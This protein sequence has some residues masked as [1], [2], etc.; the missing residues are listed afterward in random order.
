VPRLAPVATLVLSGVRV[1]ELCLLD[2][3]YLDSARRTIHVPRV[4]TDAAERSIPML[5][6]LYELLL[7]PRRVG[8]RAAGAGVRDPQ[9]HAQ[10]ARQGARADLLGHTDPKFTMR[11]Y[12]Q[13][14]DLG[15]SVPE[16]LEYDRR[17][18]R[19]LAWR[20][21]FSLTPEN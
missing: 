8:L 6:L 3:R 9:R 13:V 10:P 21:Y 18:R 5:P 19:S 14:R 1:S 11:V 16:Q 17:P 15:G 4:K 12:Q 20:R 7:E 2:G